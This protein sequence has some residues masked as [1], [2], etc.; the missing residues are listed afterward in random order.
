MWQ[1]PS[2]ILRLDL[3]L[4]I[5]ISLQLGLDQVTLKHLLVIPHLVQAAEALPM[6]N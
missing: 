2:V 4:S 6:M 1:A 5:L 3:P